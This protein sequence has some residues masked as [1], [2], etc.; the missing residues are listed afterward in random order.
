MRLADTA[1]MRFTASFS[2]KPSSP[3]LFAVF[4]TWALEDGQSSALSSLPV[5]RTGSRAIAIAICGLK[6]PLAIN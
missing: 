5:R 6:C 4:I 1:E 2:P 3:S